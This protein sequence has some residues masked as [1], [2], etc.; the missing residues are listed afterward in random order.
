MSFSKVLRTNVIETYC[1]GSRQYLTGSAAIE[2]RPVFNL[3]VAVRHCPITVNAFRSN[4]ASP[5]ASGI[6]WRT[7]DLP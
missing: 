1:F 6:T 7:V 3:H 2:G 5:G 4:P